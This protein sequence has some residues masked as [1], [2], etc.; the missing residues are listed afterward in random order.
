M[1][2]YLQVDYANYIMGFT[3]D[4]YI[5]QTFKRRRNDA[6]NAVLAWWD[7][8][9]RR[10][11]W[12]RSFSAVEFHRLGGVHIHALVSD[13]LLEN[14]ELTGKLIRTKKYCDKAFGFTHYSEPRNQAT[15]SLYC[16][17]YVTKGPGDYFFL[18]Y[19]WDLT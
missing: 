17:K 6:T 12:T 9:Y 11:G 10:L 5:T 4:A 2:S 3:W 19:G 8:M 14:N 13:D 16:A 7:I 18:G 15:V 1:N